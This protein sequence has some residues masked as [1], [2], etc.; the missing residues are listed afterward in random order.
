MTR[1]GHEVKKVGTVHVGD[2]WLP[3]SLGISLGTSLYL[4]FAMEK[5]L[6]RSIRDGSSSSGA[7][8]Q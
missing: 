7:W 5:V 8:S 2:S 4:I 3:N 1:P 6:P